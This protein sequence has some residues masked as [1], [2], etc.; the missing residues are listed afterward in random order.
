MA[1]LYHR[2]LVAFETGDI[3]AARRLQSQAIQIIAIMSRRGG[4]AAGKAMMKMLGLD[5]GPVRA[6]LQNLPLEA[7]ESLARELERAGFP[8]LVTKSALPSKSESVRQAA[9]TGVTKMGST[10]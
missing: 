1:P 10:K 8:S 9:A 5:C 6:P 7:L 3:E 4:L 2:M